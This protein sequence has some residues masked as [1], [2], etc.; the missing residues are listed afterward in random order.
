MTT[1]RMMPLTLMIA[2]HGVL[3]GVLPTSS[4]GEAA[5]GSAAGLGTQMLGLASMW[6]IPGGGSY[7]GKRQ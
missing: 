5:Y 4:N 3:P 1:I 6:K 7:D 2:V